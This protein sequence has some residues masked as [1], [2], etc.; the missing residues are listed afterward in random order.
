MPQKFRLYVAI[1]LNKKWDYYSLSYV[2][3]KSYTNCVAM[4]V[5]GVKSGK[6]TKHFG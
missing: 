4:K 1:I 6:I 2:Y 3:Y 5:E